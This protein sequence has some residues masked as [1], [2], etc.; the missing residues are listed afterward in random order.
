MGKPR[1]ANSIAG[2]A[3]CSKVSVPNCSSAVSQASAA[4]GVMERKLVVE[5]DLA[6]HKLS[7]TLPPPT[8]PS[9]RGPAR[10]FP[11]ELVLA[12]A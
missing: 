5:Y 10:N 12:N 4:A 9:L 3:T 1:S 2:A 7:C 8:L 11:T 6:H